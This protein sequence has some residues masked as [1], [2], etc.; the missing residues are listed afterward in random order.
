MGYAMCLVDDGSGTGTKIAK[1]FI[2]SDGNFYELYYYVLYSPNGGII[3]P[4]T[5]TLKVTLGAP[6]NLGRNARPLPRLR[7]TSI[8]RIW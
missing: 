2:D 1:Y 3:E 5:F 8:R 6:A 4:S 7:I